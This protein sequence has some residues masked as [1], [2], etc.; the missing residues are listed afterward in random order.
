VGA[1]EPV[2]VPRVEADPTVL[3]AEVLVLVALGDEVAVIGQPCGVLVPDLSGGP[4]RVLVVLGLLQVG[5]PGLVALDRSFLHVYE[6]VGVGGGGA[7]WV[8]LGSVLRSLS[9]MK[10]NH[11][12]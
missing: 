5:A 3:V 11:I 8:L 12:P 10:L 6:S 4:G 7:H 9:V 2:N 1:G